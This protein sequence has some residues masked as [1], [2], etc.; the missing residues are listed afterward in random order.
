MLGVLQ[1]GIGFI[2]LVGF[3]VVPGIVGEDVVA[4]FEVALSKRKGVGSFG[5]TGWVVR[6]PAGDGGGFDELGDCYVVAIG[7]R[8]GI[9]LKGALLLSRVK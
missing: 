6:A 1:F 4:F 9:L 8:A 7:G 3:D 2:I 5:A